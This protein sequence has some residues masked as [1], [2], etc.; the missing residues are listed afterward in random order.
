MS[1]C[2]VAAVIAVMFLAVMASPTPVFSQQPM[3]AAT[4]APSKPADGRA[5]ARARQKQCGTEW[6]AAKAGGKVDKG[7][8]WPKYWSACNK[9][10]KA[11]GA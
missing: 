4:G 1:K 5:A 9:R 3:Q 8:T 6:K 10:L 7:M 11:A 2:L